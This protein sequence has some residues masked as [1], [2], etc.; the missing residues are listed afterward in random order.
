[1][2]AAREELAQQRRLENYELSLE[3]ELLLR[4]DAREIRR[5]SSIKAKH[6]PVSAR[7]ASG[8]SPYGGSP[9]ASPHGS[10]YTS[11]GRES[12]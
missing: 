1:M 9:F 4:A 12:T 10:A 7:P 5:V 2:N 11:P 3:R 8:R 6:R